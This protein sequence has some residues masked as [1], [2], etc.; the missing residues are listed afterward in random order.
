MEGLGITKCKICGC[1]LNRKNLKKHLSKVHSEI[2]SQPNNRK[3]NKTYFRCN[4]CHKKILFSSLLT[5]LAKMHDFKPTVIDK[6]HEWYFTEVVV[7]YSLSVKDKV[8]VAFVKTYQRL[9]RSTHKSKINCSLCSG[10]VSRKQILDHF[11]HRHH[12]DCTPYKKSVDSVRPA[13]A[14]FYEDERS[15]D[16]YERFTKMNAGGFEL[17]KNRKH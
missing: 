2:E 7:E 1:S 17:G 12:R 4:Q 15:T 3:I 14:S 8:E 16:I 6:V 11:K 10:I 13:V 5:H 9:V